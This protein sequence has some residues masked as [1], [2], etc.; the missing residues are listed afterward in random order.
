LIWFVW[1]GLVWFGLVEGN[2]NQ[3]AVYGLPAV[4]TVYIP[5]KRKPAAAAQSL[6]LRP[7]KANQQCK[8]TVRRFGSTQTNRTKPVTF[9]FG[10]SVPFQWTTARPPAGAASG[11]VG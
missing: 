2:V 3:P 6:G 11:R 9:F 7:D 10:F 1:F 8:P 5:T 4:Y